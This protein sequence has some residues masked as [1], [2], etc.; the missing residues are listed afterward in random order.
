MNKSKNKRIYIIEFINYSGP[1][2]IEFIVCE[3]LEEAK[4]KFKE[5]IDMI[6]DCMICLD[7]EDCEGKDMSTWTDSDGRSKE[8]CLEKGKCFIEDL[9]YAEIVESKTNESVVVSY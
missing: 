9:V 1:S 5:L 4:D 7:I 8:Q 6:E 3:S 2:E